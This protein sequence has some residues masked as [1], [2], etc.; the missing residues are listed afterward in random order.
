VSNFAQEASQA[1]AF[2]FSSHAVV[3]SILNDPHK[4]GFIENDVTQ[5]EG[6]IWL[7]DLHLTNDVHRVLSQRII[8][9]LT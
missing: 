7:D 6:G 5:E 4:Y 1:T 9:A 2:V 8:A 3:E